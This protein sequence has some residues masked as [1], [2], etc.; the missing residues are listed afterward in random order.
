MILYRLENYT[1]ENLCRILRDG[2]TPTIPN[3]RHE[4]ENATIPRICTATSIQNCMTALGPYCIAQWFMEQ[5]QL[6]I[7]ELQA[8]SEKP[9]RFIV[10]KFDTRNIPSENIVNSFELYR[11]GYVPDAYITK[12]YWL[13]APYQPANICI[14]ELDSMKL[15]GRE[16]IIPYQYFKRREQFYKNSAQS[17]DVQLIRRCRWKNCVIVK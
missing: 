17:L 4:T 8:N 9:F 15:Y 6:T 13:L 3:N 7:D 10:M 11:K 5:H 1:P 12:E 14:R 16:R 2:C